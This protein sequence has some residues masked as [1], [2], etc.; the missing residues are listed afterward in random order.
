MFTVALIG[1]DGAGKTTISRRLEHALPRPVKYIYMGV[2]LD[3][4][5]VML[6]TTRVVKVVKRALGAPPDV[7]GPPDPARLKAQPKG[8]V[9]RALSGVKSV[10]RLAYQLSEEWF[11]QVLTWVYQR[12]GYIVLFDRHYFSDFYAYDI[13]HPRPGQPFTRRIHG[14]VLQHLYPRPDL[15]IYLDAPAEVLFKR[16]GEGTL[17][18]LERRRHE[19]LQM[20]D[21]VRHF[22]VVDASLP[23]DDVVRAVA[24]VISA[25]YRDRSGG[26]LRVSYGPR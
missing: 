24:G 5:N 15:V 10:L 7:A 1:P 25:F 20:R 18:A 17:D 22:V 21:L 11:R 9:K 23:V 4:S 6:P 26:E 16:K 13:A 2:N 8:L 3:S 14:F 19:Y 12:R